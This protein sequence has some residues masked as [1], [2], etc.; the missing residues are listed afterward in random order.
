MRKAGEGEIRRAHAVCPLTAIQNR[1]SMMARWHEALFPVLEELGIGY[2]AFSPM[3]NGL[4]AC[5]YGRSA[6][7]GF[8]AATD[9][10]ASMPQFTREAYEKNDALFEFLHRIAAE[11]G[12]TTGQISLAWMLGKRPWIIPIPGTSGPERMRE[13][14]A[15]A[16]SGEEN[17]RELLRSPTGG[18]SPGPSR[19]ALDWWV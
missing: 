19:Q 6:A 12:V 5:A 2:V 17:G 16:A 15:A 10:R 8:D 11:H 7:E 4:L 9:Y 14:L 1:Y 13:N 3:A 18:A